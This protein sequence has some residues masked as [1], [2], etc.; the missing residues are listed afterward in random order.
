M[1]YDNAPEHVQLAVDMIRQMENLDFPNETVLEACLL[2][3]QDTLNKMGR[4]DRV[5]WRTRLS[6]ILSA[7]GGSKKRQTAI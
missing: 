2:V 5:A 4:E 6:S 7:P 1:S 3:M